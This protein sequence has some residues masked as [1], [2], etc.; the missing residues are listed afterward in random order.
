MTAYK[1]KVAEQEYDLS[2]EEL[3]KTLLSIQVIV[4]E[5][6]KNN[7]GKISTKTN[8]HNFIR[9]IEVIFDKSELKEILVIDFN[10]NPIII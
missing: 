1:L 2:L 6:V 7:H 4:D 3:Q 8:A 9:G 10:S 5:E